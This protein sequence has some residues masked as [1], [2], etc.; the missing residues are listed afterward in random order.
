MSQPHAPLSADLAY[1]DRSSPLPLLAT[2]S[3]R[4]AVTLAKWSTRSRTRCSLSHLDPHMLRDI[5]VTP[6]EARIEANK[7]F[8]QL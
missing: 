7:R 2:L 1:L 3:V 5:G 8:W 4:V 6:D